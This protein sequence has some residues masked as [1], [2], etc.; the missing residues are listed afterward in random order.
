MLAAA[1]VEKVNGEYS[2]SLN[3]SRAPFHRI[4]KYLSSF[5]SFESL[6]IPNSKLGHFFKSKLLMK[7]TYD[8]ISSS[9]KVLND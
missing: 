6:D 9:K 2:P 8:K 1:K 5:D 4:S 3:K 7:N